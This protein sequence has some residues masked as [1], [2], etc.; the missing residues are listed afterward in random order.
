MQILFFYSTDTM[1]SGF[2]SSSINA[3]DPNLTLLLCFYQGL[4]T[5]ATH[6]KRPPTMQFEQVSMLWPTENQLFPKD[7]KLIPHWIPLE[8]SE[9]F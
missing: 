9:I 6:E 3:T 4:T 5:N 8:A 7:I 2:D 1:A